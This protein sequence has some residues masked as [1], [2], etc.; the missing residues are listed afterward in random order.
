MY[1]RFWV[2]VTVVL[3]LVFAAIAFPI[4][5]RAKGAGTAVVYTVV[6]FVVIWFA[7]FA[8]AWVFSRPGF[9]GGEGRRRDED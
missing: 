9:G 5:L 7:Y 8:R 6:G 3:C 1:N 2:T 4:F